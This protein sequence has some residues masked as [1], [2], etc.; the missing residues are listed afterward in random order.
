MQ[1]PKSHVKQLGQPGRAP[2]CSKK[3][4]PSNGASIYKVLIGVT[5][6]SRQSLALSTPLVLGRWGGHRC[7]LSHFT[8][9]LAAGFLGEKL[10]AE[11]A[12]EEQRAERAPEELRAERGPEKLR[13]ERAPEEQ[14]AERAPEELRAERGPEKLRAERAPAEKLRAER[15]PEELRAGSGGPKPGTNR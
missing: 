6:H 2:R 9:P 3:V 15:A 8:P 4:S 13:A 5:I 11:R 12:P 14:R 1:G 7:R 10:R